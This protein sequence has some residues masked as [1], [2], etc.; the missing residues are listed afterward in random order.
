MIFVKEKKESQ[1]I[2]TATLTKPWFYSPHQILHQYSVVMS[3][4]YH[5][6][7]GNNVFAE[8][9]VTI[10]L[11]VIIHHYSSVRYPPVAGPFLPTT[12]GIGGYYNEI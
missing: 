6:I 11:V 12:K 7:Y 4:Y 3:E 10:N 1:N 5:Q 8:N 2:A 9:I